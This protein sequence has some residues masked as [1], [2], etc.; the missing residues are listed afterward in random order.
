MQAALDGEFGRGWVAGTT[1]EAIP[2][3][4]GTQDAEPRILL[5]AVLLKDSEENVRKKGSI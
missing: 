2:S 5:R 4:S 1:V 3:I